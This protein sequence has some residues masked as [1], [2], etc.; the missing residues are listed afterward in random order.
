MK[1]IK[2]IFW[3]SL[4]GLTLLWLI[5]DSLIFSPFDSE[6]LTESLMQYTGIISLGAMSIAMILATKSTW[7]ENFVDGLDK[8]YR[9]HKWLGIAAFVFALVHWLWSELPGW[10]GLEDGEYYE[11]YDSFSGEVNRGGNILESLDSYGRTIGEYC[12]YLVVILLVIALVK[13]IPYR[14]FVKTHIIMAVVYLGL[15]FHAITLMDFGYWT[16]PIGVVMYILMLAGTLSA[17]IILFGQAGKRRKV[18][19]IIK[20]IITYPK[21]DMFELSVEIGYNWKGHKEGQFAFLKFKDA[22]PPHPF[23]ISSA[24]N[25]NTDE[26]SFTIKALGDYTNTLINKLKVDDSI[27]L[28]GPYGCFTFE[29]NISSQIW[30][31]GG[32]GITPFLARMEQLAKSKNKQE[33]N[34]FYTV[35]DLDSDLEKKLK[36]L[37]E[38]ANINLHLF[39][40]LENERISG[41]KIRHSVLNW[42][43]T[44]I[45]FCGP[46]KMGTSIKKDLKKNEFN[47]KN[48]HQELFKMR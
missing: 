13:K 9:L 31:A 35:K 30:I 34:F 37:V 28:E 20:S 39:N 44:S 16:Q 40:T 7:F 41:E 36:E 38:A 46:S 32:V 22:E 33:I 43:S 2:I 47:I 8:S 27:M 10:I 6:L 5:S 25:S 3:V 4:I 12:F 24:W 15:V 19:G 29:N 45:W 14:F 1:N 11:D 21:M 26:I 42:K 17:L 48:F 18:V 23:T